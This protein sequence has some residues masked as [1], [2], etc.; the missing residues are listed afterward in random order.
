[1]EIL[2][3]G[4]AGYIGSVCAEAL[5]KKGCRVVV[6]DNLREGN[7]AAIHPDCIF[8]EVDMGDREMLDSV[9]L[10]HDIEV[11]MHFAAEATIETSMTDPHLYFMNNVVNGI[12]IL[13]AM[14]KAGCNKLIF[15]STAAIFGTPEYVPIDEEHVK[16]P[17]NA[18]GESKLM[19]EHIL[20]WYH[21][22]YGL[23]FNAFRYFNAAGAAGRL[24]EA[25][26]HETHLIPCIIN[27]LLGKKRKMYIY[28]S[29]YRTKDGT[30]VRDYLHVLDIAKAHILAME[31]LEKRSNRKYNLGNGRGFTN[32]EVLRTVETVAGKKIPFELADRRPGDPPELVAS[33]ELAKKELG[34]KPQY[35]SLEL[36]IQSAW[37]WH[38]KHPNG[39]DNND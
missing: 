17:I 8:Y 25:H 3:T 14:R 1:M 6:V 26:R 2:V 22:S 35:K 20:N 30:C 21:A 31:N 32:L 19:F 24:G 33:S 12:N 4:G 15:S 37:E 5:M 13:E 18:Y 11:V 29:D 27:T 28:G 38:E 7:K 39:Y 9:F 36:I 23:K 34:W 10:K 16:R